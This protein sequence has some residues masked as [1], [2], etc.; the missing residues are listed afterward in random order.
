MIM[1]NKLFPLAVLV[2]SISLLAGFLIIP[3]SAAEYGGRCLRLVAQDEKSNVQMLVDLRGLEPYTDY[4]LT[5]YAKYKVTYVNK[6]GY[7]GGLFSMIPNATPAFAAVQCYD[8]ETKDWELYSRTFTTLGASKMKTIFLQIC[9]WHVKG[10]FLIDNIKITKIETNEVVLQEDFETVKPF[11]I[12][13]IDHSE[14]GKYTDQ[15]PY[16]V[17][18]KWFAYLAEDRGVAGIYDL[19]A[20]K[21]LTGDGDSPKPIETDDP[22]GKDTDS[23]STASVKDTDSKS[24]KSSADN[25]KS[26]KT[27][28]LDPD[29]SDPS[30]SFEGDDNSF[31]DESK[32]YSPSGTDNSDSSKQPAINVDEPGNGTSTF[33]YIGI[34][35]LVVLAGAAAVYFMVIRKKK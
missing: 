5:M 9:M 19:N 30:A 35:L 33:I 15:N 27:T 17:E 7:S 20:K 14:E 6:E 32:E 1:K 16:P 4:E 18:G 8:P 13:R 10:E 29:V 34:G 24:S 28:S 12:D 25:T 2:L 22:D 31:S 21:Y 11:W 26:G 23:K 3:A